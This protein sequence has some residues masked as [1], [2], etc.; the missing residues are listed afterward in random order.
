MHDI[1]TVGHALV[2]C[3]QIRLS[4]RDHERGEIQ[5]IFEEL[6]EAYTI[7]LK[8]QRPDFIGWAGNLLGEVLAMGGHPDEAVDVLATAAAAWEKIGRADA[9][10]QCRQ[11]IEQIRGNA[12]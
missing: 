5:T 2:Y 10:A 4:R 3:A 8:L 9:A 11:L 1:D 12:S 7:S 6:S